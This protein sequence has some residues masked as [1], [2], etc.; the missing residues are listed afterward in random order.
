VVVTGTPTLELE[1]GSIDDNAT[2]S[3]GTGTDNLTFVYSVSTDDSSID[4]DYTSTSSLSGTIKDSAGNNAVLTLSSPGSSGSLA[5]NNNL[6]IQGFNMGQGFYFKAGNNNSCARNYGYSVAKD[7][8]T[9]AIGA[10]ADCSNQTGVTNGTTSSS[11]SSVLNVGAVYIYRLNN[12]TWT[13]ESYIKPDVASSYYFGKT[14][15]LDNGT[16][17]VGGSGYVWVFT[18]SGTNWSQEAKLTTDTGYFTAYTDFFGWSVSLSGDTIA[19]GA[20]NDDSNQTSITNTDNSSS[21]DGSAS[22]S[23]AVYVFTR[24]GTSWTQDAYIKPSNAETLDYFGGQVTLSGD[25]LA[26]YAA[27]EDSNQTSITNDDNTS[28]SNNSFSNSGAVYLFNRSGNNWF[29][30]AYLKPPSIATNNS[31]YR[32][33]ST[34]ASTNYG[35]SMDIDNMTLAV[36]TLFDGSNSGSII[37]GSTLPTQ[38]DNVSF[39]LRGAAIIYKYDG[40]LWSQESYIK[41]STMCHQEYGGYFDCNQDT[42]FGES[43]DLEGDVVVVGSPNN[44]VLQG[45][46]IVSGTPY[47]DDPAL[48]VVGDGKGG[49]AFLF[50]RSGSNWS[51]KAVIKASNADNDDDFSGGPTG[52]SID[53][54]TIII[55]APMERST[56]TTI[57]TSASTNN[58]MPGS[59]A[60]YLFTMP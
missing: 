59:G 24:S 51:Q 34:L 19:V 20:V 12:S 49:A 56:Q 14:L 43:I 11:D 42:F 27:C 4:L 18:R 57:T 32:G 50:Q 17:A 5:S 53:N 6:V 40:T 15:S 28:S 54:N 26:V 10:P 31:L 22:N 47:K 58:S 21:T 1:T 25:L 13:Q 38:N 33:C 52:I 37:N 8:D 55:G 7:G 41:P 29:Q 45:R 3:S 30:D 48:N 16:L 9:I 35:H 60:A 44:T 2:Y 36:G 39:L 23:G 46:S